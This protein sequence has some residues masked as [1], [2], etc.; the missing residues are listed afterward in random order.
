MTPSVRNLGKSDLPPTASYKI[1]LTRFSMF[2]SQL[3]PP[4]NKKRGYKKKFLLA[5]LAD[6]T[7]PLS[8]PWR[9]PCLWSEA[10]CFRVVL[11]PSVHCPSVLSLTHISHDTISLYTYSG[12]ISIG[13]WTQI[14]TTSVEIAEKFFCVQNVWWIST[15]WGQGSIIMICP[16]FFRSRSE[17]LLTSHHHCLLTFASL[18][19]F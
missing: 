11:R 19:L 7:P 9:R 2:S 3:Y 17:P 14:F 8:N 18:P 5:S 12:A 15:A 16:W 10:L 4:V 6:C 1:R 13:N